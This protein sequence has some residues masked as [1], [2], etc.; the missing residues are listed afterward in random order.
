MTRVAAAD[1]VR[2]IV[3]RV[4]EVV[5]KPLNIHGYF[6]HEKVHAIGGYLPMGRVEYYHEEVPI[7]MGKY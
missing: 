7:S 1:G 4:L 2:E 5:A 3:N 6:I